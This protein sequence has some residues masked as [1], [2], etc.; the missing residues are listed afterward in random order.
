MMKNSRKRPLLSSKVAPP[1]PTATT[2]MLERML[3]AG[4]KKNKKK[5]LVVTTRK[6]EDSLKKN[7][8]SKDS[9]SANRWSHMSSSKTSVGGGGGLASAPSFRT[10][11]TSSVLASRGGLAAAPSF[12]KSNSVLASKG[13]LAAAPRFKRKSITE[14]VSAK[15]NVRTTS[16]IVSMDA[17]AKEN[18][19]VTEKTCCSTQEMKD[20]EIDPPKR[21]GTTLENID[22]VEDAVTK[23]LAQSATACDAFT[24]APT[25]P[26][27]PKAARE[28]S[29]NSSLRL[30]LKLASKQPRKRMLD[31]RNTNRAEPVLPPT[32][33]DESSVLS[34]PNLPL[35][36]GESLTASSSA[37]RN[38]K[39]KDC[40]IISTNDSSTMVNQPAPSATEPRITNDSSNRIA[41][42]E[43][44]Q[45]WLLQ[46]KASM[47]TQPPIVLEETK[48]GFSN[49]A[50][51]KRP[52]NNDNFV[53]T[54]LRNSAG[55]CRG[56]RNKK[57]MRKFRRYD[58]D[59]SQDG[60]EKKKYKPSSSASAG[61]Q[62]YVS[63]MTGLDPL[64]DYLDGVFHA[65]SSSKTKT[66]YNNQEDAPKCARHQKICKLV[67]VKK[68]TTGNK[69]R[70]FYACSM[71][72]GEQCNHFQWAADTVEEARR[73]LLKNTSHS[74][75]IARQV[76]AHV[77]R[78]RCLTVPELR[79]EAARRKLS[80]G[81]KKQELLIRLAIWARN[82]IVKVAPHDDEEKLDADNNEGAIDLTKKSNSTNATEDV[83]ID[84]EE[85]D[86]SSDDDSTSSEELEL[87]QDEDGD[88]D[89][90]E[91]GDDDDDDDDDKLVQSSDDTEK[92]D[93]SI[94]ESSKDQLEIT[95]TTIFGHDNFREGQKWA[96]QRC[97][98]GKK[99]LLVA[100]TGFGKSLCYVFPAAVMDGVCVVV[101]PLI[102]LIQVCI[103]DLRKFSVS[104][105][106][107][108]NTHGFSLGS[109][110]FSSS[111][112]SCSDTIRKCYGCSNGCNFG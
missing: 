41:A 45:E 42:D 49:A 28:S 102:S 99:S 29:S 69:G 80:K 46:S 92:G 30:G 8:V 11:S 17:S 68:N 24:T 22:T 10:T 63:R 64:D 76:A 23:P 70:K 60:D 61:G 81:G 83:E 88:N 38:C 94:D 78:F 106:V 58:N 111:S 73:T 9:T 57:R 16:R 93:N 86:D 91:G 109:T 53:R 33:S 65:K 97:L 4:Q 95:L 98:D 71:P 25:I 6:L 105:S 67:V 107:L 3:D 52:V 112:S 110:P 27:P 7:I 75:F 36:N 14:A 104:S 43:K 26:F 35:P 39:N 18:I 47:H 66:S 77:D 55:A 103:M 108:R 51:K 79:E 82:E 90:G 89:F 20:Q 19:T 21:R 32:I 100:P 50:T 96:I 37:D 85:S 59:Y 54:N 87:F 84:M 15:P 40:S 34:L 74:S 1:P 56:A 72:R 62:Q 31:S 13:G 2:R 5:K 101:S 44:Q 12:K 48:A